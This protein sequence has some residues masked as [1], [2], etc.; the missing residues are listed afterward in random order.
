ME[1]NT[2]VRGRGQRD[3]IRRRAG[4]DTRAKRCLRDTNRAI[5]AIA[6]MTAMVRH[7]LHR[8]SSGGRDKGNF[9]MSARLHSMRMRQRPDDRKA[10]IRYQEQQTPDCRKTLS[11]RRTHD[12]R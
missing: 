3:E 1:G 2:G 12:C 8:M 10:K 9:A 5:R 11:H 4:D 6:A 7:R